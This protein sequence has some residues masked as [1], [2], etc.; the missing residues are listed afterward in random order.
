MS[1]L[2]AGFRDLF[3]LRRCKILFLLRQSI[4]LLRVLY[5]FHRILGISCEFLS[6]CF[7]FLDYLIL[8]FLINCGGKDMNSLLAFL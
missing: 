8:V 7:L 5:A 2:V 1:L 4:I 6:T 3:I